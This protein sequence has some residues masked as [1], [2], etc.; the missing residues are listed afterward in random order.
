VLPLPIGARTDAH[1]ARQNSAL[2]TTRLVLFAAEDLTAASAAQ[3]SRQLRC[4]DIAVRCIDKQFA[5]TALLCND[6]GEG[7]RACR[8]WVVVEGHHRPTSH[9]C[10]EVSFS[11]VFPC[12]ITNQAKFTHADTPGPGVGEDANISSFSGVSCCVL[13]MPGCRACGS[14]R[15]RKVRQGTC[16]ILCSTFVTTIGRTLPSHPTLVVQI[17]HR[18]SHVVARLEDWT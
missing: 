18:T 7:C 5:S 11:A 12:N 3:V 6:E 10:M 4:C 16:R 17:L 9:N 13:D 15:W 1:A 14:C 8:V 2:Q